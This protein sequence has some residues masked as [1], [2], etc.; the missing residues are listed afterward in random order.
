MITTYGEVMLRLSPAETGERIKTA[1][2]FRVEPGGSECNVAIALAS[3]GVTSNFVTRLPEND[4]SEAI[5]SYLRANK[6]GVKDIDFGG[7][8]IGAYWTEIG[9]GIRNSFVIYDR[10]YSS[11]SD[12]RIT[13]FEWQKIEAKSEWF[14]FSGITPALTENVAKDLI[15]LTDSI[16]LP[17]SVD[18]N[19]RANLWQWI[20][21]SDMSIAQVMT[22]VCN[23]AKLIVG[24]ET[25]CRDIFSIDSKEKHKEQKY[26]V[27]ARR[28]FAKFPNAQFIALSNRNS[29]SATHNVWSGFLFVRG[30][31]VEVYEGPTYDLTDIKDRVGTGDSFAAGIIYGLSSRNDFSYQN[32]VDFA[33]TLSALN[34]STRG[35]FST[36]TVQDVERALVTRGSGRIV[37]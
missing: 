19:Y 11:F 33:V 32:I 37:R 4:L 27:I 17:Y 1:K 13:D 18:L 8:R 16:S 9:N 28:M 30:N 36:F 23:K 5:L 14:H 26:R 7:E 12:S 3:L 29:V 34:H 24:N 20:A 22:K 35:D 10:I 6:V 31:S 2:E 25:D 15:A 21:N